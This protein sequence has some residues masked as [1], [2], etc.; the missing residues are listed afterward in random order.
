[1]SAA[2]TR[3]LFQCHN[4]S[5]FFQTQQQGKR[6]TITLRVKHTVCLTAKT[7]THRQNISKHEMFLWTKKEKTPFY[8]LNKQTHFEIVN[9]P[10]PRKNLL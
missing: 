9:F 7:A 3:L 4:S 8:L 6:N 5:F 1:M 2:F 10:C